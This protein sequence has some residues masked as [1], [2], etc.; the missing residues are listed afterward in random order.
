MRSRGH[1]DEPPDYR[2]CRHIIETEEKYK[3]RGFLGSQACIRL[4]VERKCADRRAAV[5]FLSAFALNVNPLPSLSSWTPARILIKLAGSTRSLHVS[6]AS[7]PISPRH[8]R[9][10]KAHFSRL[11]S[12][13]SNV[14][15]AA[16]PVS[17]VYQQAA[18]AMDMASGAAAE[19]AAPAII[20]GLPHRRTDVPT[21]HHLHQSPYPFQP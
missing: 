6:L 21:T 11:G 19:G 5:S 4:E 14:T 9:A 13:K 3:G 17:G 15:R 1:I 7:E 16:P 2:V 20:N 18:S 8:Q 12:E 10:I